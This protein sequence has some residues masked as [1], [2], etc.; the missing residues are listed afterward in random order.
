MNLAMPDQTPLLRVS[1]ITK[2]FGGLVALRNVSFDLAKGEIAA[3]IGPN[4]AGKTTLV[5]VITGVE[6]AQSGTVKFKGVD[7]G[8]LPAYEIARRG[9]GRSFQIV[10]PFPD[11]TVSENVTAAALFGG[12]ASSRAEARDK[13]EEC[14]A[15]TGL[16]ASIAKPAS[17]LT[18]PE[19]KRLELA[20]GLATKPD[21][22]LLDEVNAGLNATEIET[23][24]ELIR[25]IASRGVTIILIEHLMRVVLRVSGRILVLHQ[26]ELIADGAPSSVIR[27]PQVIEAYLG[28]GFHARPQGTSG[29]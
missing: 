20:K 16:S 6:R 2:R 5:N 24:L 9:I 22:L 26:G 3:L 8:G 28:Q 23:A 11:M 7:V 10:Q 18:L 4:G 13:A 19:R 29:A 27:L 14:L 17:S 1:G 25:A 21:L 12:R 15:F